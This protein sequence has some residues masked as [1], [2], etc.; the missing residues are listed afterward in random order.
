MG[1][2]AAEG[3]GPRRVFALGAVTGAAAVGVYALSCGSM[4]AATSGVC[5]PGATDVA[6]INT[7][8]GLGSTT[9]QGALDEIGTTMRKATGATSAIA[10]AG[11]IPTIWTIQQNL[12][13]PNTETMGSTSMGTVTFVEASPGQGSYETSGANVFM[14]DGLAGPPTGTRTGKYFLVGDWLLMTGQVSSTKTGYTWLARL[15]DFGQTMTLNNAGAVVLV[16]S[17]Q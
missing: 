8:S 15:S 4:P 5:P 12:L 13:D 9:V 7:R 3:H 6:Y 10:D 1:D 2:R 14:L 17:K 16:L 11:G